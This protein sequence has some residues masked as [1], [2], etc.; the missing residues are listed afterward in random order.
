MSKYE[1]AG[2]YNY[3]GKDIIVF[4]KIGRNGIISFK[5]KS[6][7]MKN[8]DSHFFPDSVYT[9]MGHFKKLLGEV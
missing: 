8:T 2:T 3:K 6:L 4:Y 5:Y 9:L 7:T 1:V